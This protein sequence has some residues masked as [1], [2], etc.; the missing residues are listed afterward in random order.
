M[1]YTP[2]ELC[3]VAQP[4]ILAAR[5]DLGTL[6][7]AYQNE[8][9]AVLLWAE[10]IWANVHGDSHVMIVDTATSIIWTGPLHLF[11]SF[12]NKGIVYSISGP[13]LEKWDE[14]LIPIKHSNRA[15]S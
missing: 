14:R 4:S 8:V 1:K 11:V 10:P 2:G 7:E 3:K 5:C 6:V 9:S 13:I 12:V 15:S